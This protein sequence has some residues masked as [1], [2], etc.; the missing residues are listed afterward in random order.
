[1]E[2]IHTKIP[3]GE[4]PIMQVFWEN[5]EKYRLENEINHSELCR[6][7][8]TDGPSYF[9]NKAEFRNIMPSTMQR[10]AWALGVKTL[11][12]FEDWSD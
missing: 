12:L 10:Y 3:A 7:V 1:M 11:D 6:K 2:K 4:R 9:R 5:V 8:G